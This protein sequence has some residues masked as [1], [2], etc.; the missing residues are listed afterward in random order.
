M[1]THPLVDAHLHLWDTAAHPWYPQL[2]EFASA[3]GKPEL[4]ANFLPADFER[5]TAGT[6]VAGLV[7]VSATTAPHAYLAETRWVESLAPVLARPLAIVGSVDPA[8]P[9]AELIEHLEIQARSQHFRGLRVF[10]GLSP[11]TPAADAIAGWLQDHDAVFDLVARPAD[12]LD[13]IDF[14]AGY[15]GLRVVLEHLGFPDSTAPEAR[16]AWRNAISLAARETPWLCKMSGLGMICPDLSWPTLEYWLETA[17]HLW[18]WRRLVF[19]SNMPIDSRAGSYTELLGT[20]DHIV[21]ADAT[22][23]EAEF[24]YRANA[25]EAYRLLLPDPRIPARPL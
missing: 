1:P 20:I 11:A 16:T 8:L 21:A 24:F 10:E 25:G 15:P 9:K 18:G 17:V 5:V 4:A 19:A 3:A 13:W 2:T 12:I 6:E 22:D 23:R 7:H 14:L